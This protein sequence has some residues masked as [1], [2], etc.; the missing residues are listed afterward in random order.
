M[1]PKVAITIGD[2]AGIGPEIVFKAVNSLKVQRVC[3]PVVFGDKNIIKNYFDINN[4]KYEFI[5]TS[6][7][8]R[9]VKLSSPSK[10]A[11]LIAYNAIEQAV[12]IC[13][14]NK[15]MPLVTAPVSKESFKLAQTKYFAH[16]E[17]LADLT[18]TKKFCMMMVCGNINSVMV[19]RHLP[20]SAMAQAHQSTASHISMLSSTS[21]ARNCSTR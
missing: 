20:I 12:K 3:S 10:Q 19:T 21:T 18:K 11:G 9:K 14:K 15:D 7:F 8:G 6:N 5:F 2:P 13:L 1:K 17:I 16:T 4:S